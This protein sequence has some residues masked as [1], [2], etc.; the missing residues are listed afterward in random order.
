[1][2][3]RSISGRYLLQ[4]LSEAA[5]KAIDDIEIVSESKRLATLQAAFALKGHILHQSGTCTGH[6]HGTGPVSYMTTRWGLA[7]YFHTLDNAYKFLI[8]VGGSRHE[9]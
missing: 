6:G 7:G 3:V 4:H 2:S 5:Q 9:L 1:M 8:Q